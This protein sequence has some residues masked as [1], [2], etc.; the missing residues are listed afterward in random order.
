RLRRVLRDEF[1][2]RLAELHLRCRVLRREAHGGAIVRL[3]FWKLALGERRITGLDKL[4][5]PG[6]EQKP[7]GADSAGAADH[8]EDGEPDDERGI[9][10]FLFLGHESL[11]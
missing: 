2:A 5:G 10:A 3:G 8:N 6:L 9:D 1:D 4:V 7:L 11:A